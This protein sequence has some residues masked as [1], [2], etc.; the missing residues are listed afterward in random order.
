MIDE[1][2]P[3]SFYTKEL[4]NTSGKST[5]NPPRR[6][7]LVP[8]SQWARVFFFKKKG[9]CWGETKRLKERTSVP[10]ALLLTFFPDLSQIIPVD[11]MVPRGALEKSDNTQ[12]CRHFWIQDPYDSHTPNITAP[13]L[14]FPL[15]RSR[16]S[17][18]VLVLVRWFR[19]HDVVFQL[20]QTPTYRLRKARVI[21]PL[22]LSEAVTVPL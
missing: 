2:F 22:K 3:A 17:C 1:P 14:P 7:G 13:H 12:F 5:L 6:L 21:P 11:M 8:G 16:G 15:G 19:T 9:S 10:E 4:R 20:S 18:S